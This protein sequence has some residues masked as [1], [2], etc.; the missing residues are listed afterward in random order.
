MERWS[1][2]AAL[3]VRGSEP[4]SRLSREQGAAQLSEL[5][6]QSR[7][8]VDKSTGREPRYTAACADPLPGP[9]FSI[10]YIG[11]ASS[12]QPHRVRMLTATSGLFI[13]VSK[14]LLDCH[15]RWV[16]DRLGGARGSRQ[17]G[18]ALSS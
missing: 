7:S 3:L 10:Y 2:A 9:R 14:Y 17:I 18:D 16:A 6:T 1:G 11:S 13:L 8:G 15:L 4:I 12:A 5:V